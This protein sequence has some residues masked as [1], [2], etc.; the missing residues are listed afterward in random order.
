MIGFSVATLPFSPKH[1]TAGFCHRIWCDD[2]VACWFIS[3]KKDEREMTSPATARGKVNKPR[4]SFDLG[5]C[6]QFPVAFA[7]QFWTI[8]RI[9]CISSI[10]SLWPAFEASQSP[11]E[12]NKPIGIARYAQGVCPASCCDTPN[13]SA[14]KQT[15]AI[16]R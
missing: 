1:I 13:I 2:S 15:V 16:A 9:C 4:C 12:M 6:V 14:K 11:T 10:A 3:I 5:S 8:E 7:T